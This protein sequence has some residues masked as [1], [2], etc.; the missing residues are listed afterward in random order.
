M[1]TPRTKENFFY[2]RLPVKITLLFGI[3]GIGV[4]ILWII[5]T[6]LIQ[7]LLV[8]GCK[9]SGGVVIPSSQAAPDFFPKSTTLPLFGNQKCQRSNF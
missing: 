3:V 2:G 8:N 7:R 4:V 6:P 1:N 5:T 9:S